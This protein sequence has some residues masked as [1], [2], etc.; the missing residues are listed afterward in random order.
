MGEAGA[1]KPYS[2]LDTT[3]IKRGVEAEHG[4]SISLELRLH[5]APSASRPE[6]QRQLPQRDGIVVLPLAHKL[7]LVP[8]LTQLDLERFHDLCDCES[9]LAQG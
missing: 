6:L 9:E 1:V 4:H 2:T 3:R 7:L 5:T 8:A